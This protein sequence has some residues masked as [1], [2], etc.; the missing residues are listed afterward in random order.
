ML[1]AFGEGNDMDSIV[2]FDDYKRC[3][4][5]LNKSNYNDDLV[6]GSVFF[7]RSAISVIE[8]YYRIIGY[9]IC[10]EKG[11][12]YPIDVKN[13]EITMLEGT[14]NCLTDKLKMELVPYNIQVEPLTIW[15]SFFFRWQFM[16]DWDA[17][18][19]SGSFIKLSSL[20]IENDLLVKKIIDERINFVFPTNYKELSQMVCGLNKLFGVTFYN[21][22]FYEEINYLFDS[23][24]SGYHINMSKDEVDTYCYQF[25]DYV[26]KK[27]EAENV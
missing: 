1:C 7:T 12:Y 22:D 25:C 24:L 19:N 21:K 8:K 26:L 9:I 15:S 4:R 18:E 11:L 14:Y 16:C 13:D 17:F 23:L 3:F 6:V 2:V 5:K 10:D 27:V 20:I